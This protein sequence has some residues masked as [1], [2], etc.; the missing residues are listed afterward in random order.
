MTKGIDEADRL[1][2]ARAGHAG[3]RSAVAAGRPFRKVGIRAVAAVLSVRSSLT[4]QSI[5]NASRK[6]QETVRNG[7]LPGKGGKFQPLGQ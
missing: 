3:S 1:N 4:R 5:G 6:L 7:Q 2:G